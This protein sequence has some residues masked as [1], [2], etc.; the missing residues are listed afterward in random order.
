[1]TF[2]IKSIS[3]IKTISPFG[4]RK[5]SLYRVNDTDWRMNITFTPSVGIDKSNIFCFSIEEASGYR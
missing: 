2:N 5:S 4:M 1:M 3:E